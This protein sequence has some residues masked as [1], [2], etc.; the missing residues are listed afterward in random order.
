MRSFTKRPEMYAFDKML[1]ESFEWHEVAWKIIAPFV[2]VPATASQDMDQAIDMVARRA[3]IAVRTLTGNHG[4]FTITGRKPSGGRTEYDKMILGDQPD[5]FFCGYGTGHGRPIEERTIPTW[6]L[7]DL[8]LARP[9][10]VANHGEELGPSYKSG[11]YFYSMSAAALARDV[12]AAIRMNTAAPA[13]TP[14]DRTLCL[15]EEI[16]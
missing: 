15:F 4:T 16:A 8:S 3:T 7:I 9:W 12:P 6:F 5:L 1:K 2:L 11:C 13:A 10:I 14:L